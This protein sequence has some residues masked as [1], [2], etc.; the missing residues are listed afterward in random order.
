MKSLVEICL[1]CFLTVL[2]SDGEDDCWYIT[3]GW[4]LRTTRSLCDFACMVPWLSV[5]VRRLSPAWYKEQQMWMSVCASQC[6]EH[7]CGPL[8]RFCKWSTTLAPQHWQWLPITIRAQHHWCSAFWPG[9]SRP[10]RSFLLQGRAGTSPMIEGPRRQI[11]CVGCL[12]QFLPATSDWTLM[13]TRMIPSH[14][15]D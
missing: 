6:L 12:H 13:K 3:S 11:C 15:E 14:F 8:W 2:S 10:F 9:N 7:L 4:N 5:E 1:L